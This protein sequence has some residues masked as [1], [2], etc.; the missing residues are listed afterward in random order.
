MRRVLPV[1]LMSLAVVAFV[2]TASGA[3]GWLALAGVA[4]ALALSV[5]GAHHQAFLLSAAASPWP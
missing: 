3:A 4:V 2:P 5:S 1:A